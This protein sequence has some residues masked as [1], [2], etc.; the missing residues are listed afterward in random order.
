MWAQLFVEFI[1]TFLFLSVVLQGQ[2][3][4]IG[5]A[6]AAAILFG[7]AISGGHFNPAIS[8]M[9]FLNGSLASQLLI[10]Y[11]IAQCLGGIAAMYFARTYQNFL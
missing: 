2:A 1:G 9:M 6:L 11:I 7:G 4:S 10:P 3:I 8:L 5:I